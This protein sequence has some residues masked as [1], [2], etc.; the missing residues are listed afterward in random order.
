MTFSSCWEKKSFIRDKIIFQWETIGSS[1]CLFKMQGKPFITNILESGR[2]VFDLELLCSLRQFRIIY[3]RQLSSE[4]HLP[5]INDHWAFTR[6]L[7]GL[8]IGWQ[9][10]TVIWINRLVPMGRWTE[11]W[12]SVCIL[13]VL[14]NLC[15]IVTSSRHFWKRWVALWKMLHMTDGLEK[16]NEINSGCFEHMVNFYSI[17]CFWLRDFLWI[18]SHSTNS[19]SGS[20]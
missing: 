20:F 13:N 18:I 16:F 19:N 17:V 3:K 12:R 8:L 14:S 5:Y 15:H 2:L 7:R 9:L 4:H 1:I 10:N 11:H 6:A